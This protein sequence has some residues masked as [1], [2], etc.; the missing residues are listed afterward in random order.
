[1]RSILVLI[2]DQRIYLLTILPLLLMSTQVKSEA[3]QDQTLIRIYYTQNYVKENKQSATG[4]G[5]GIALTFE[6]A[7]SVIERQIN[8]ETKYGAAEPVSVPVAF[9]VQYTDDIKLAQ[10]QV[11]SQID[12][13][14]RDFSLRD[15]MND[16][17]ND[18]DGVYQKLAVDTE[19][20][21]HAA[22]TP[23]SEIYGDG[24]IHVSKNDQPWNVWDEMK[25]D[26]Y[27]G[28]PSFDPQE[29]LNVWV[30]DLGDK[31]GS[32]STVPYVKTVND[33]IVLDSRFFGTDE[34]ATHSYNQGKTLTHLVGNFLGLRDLWSIHQRCGDDL[35]QDTP[36][37][38]DPNTGCPTYEHL[39]F[40]DKYQREMTMNFMDSTSDNC[41]Y[42]F[43]ADQKKRMHAMLRI[44]RPGL[45]SQTKQR[46]GL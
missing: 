3:H 16:H 29:V 30:A 34:T 6:E 5:H 24:L 38:N 35:T 11:K 45:I 26:K 12:A 31:I 20:R 46:Q 21:F 4:S 14:N 40:C 22:L 18:P 42:M 39:S 25:Q 33:G 8:K 17:P 10:A 28:S 23:S 2:A 19:I 43:T 15:V 37:H 13:L 44:A 41:Q 1:M 32:Y 36:I 27:G 9:H 7:E